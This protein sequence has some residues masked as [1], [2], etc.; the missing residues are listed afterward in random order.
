FDPGTR[1]S[2]GRLVRANPVDLPAPSPLDQIDVNIIEKVEIFKGPSAATLYGPDAANGVIVI[3]TKRG[4][5]GPTRWSA[6]L[7]HSRTNALGQYPTAYFRWGHAY[8][9]NAPTFCTLTNNICVQD[10]L[11]QFQA[12]NDP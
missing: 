9:D 5:P 6:N 10:S 7:T 8:Y 11:V 1:D 12:L 2:A 3:T 4:K